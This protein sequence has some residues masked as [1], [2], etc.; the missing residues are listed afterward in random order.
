MIDIIRDIKVGMEGVIQTYLGP[1][2]KRMAYVNDVEKN[3]YNTDSNRYGVRALAGGDDPGVTNFVTIRQTFE[4]VLSKAYRQS[5]L[6]DLEQFEMSLD[7]FNNMLS[8]YKEL[9]N[10]KAGV[11]LKVLNITNI[12]MSEPEYLVQS[13]VAIQRATMDVIYRFSLI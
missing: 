5:S 6:D 7:N 2:Y 10:F 1:T 9:V 13:K 12:Q 4:V 8:I 11:P 3:N